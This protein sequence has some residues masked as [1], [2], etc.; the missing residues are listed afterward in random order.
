MLRRRGHAGTITL[1]SADADPPCDRPNLSKDYLAGTAPEDWIPLRGAG[2]YAEQAIDLRLGVEVERLDLAAHEVVA[3]GGERFAFDA[4]L[5]AT[6][7]E[8]IRPRSP[9]FDLPNV[10]VL[11]T[12]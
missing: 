6:G 3:R 5:L 12:L 1:L 7:A 11:R 10:H 2:W 8:P 4:L 9:G